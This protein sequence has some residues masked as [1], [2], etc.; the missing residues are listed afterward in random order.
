[1]Q[2]LT[3]TVRLPCWDPDVGVLWAGADTDCTTRTGV[4]GLVPGARSGSAQEDL[5]TLQ[6]KA[7]SGGLVGAFWVAVK[8]F[9]Y[10]VYSTRKIIYI[11][12]HRYQRTGFLNYG[13][14][15]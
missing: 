1:M 7:V 11:Y 2:T 3:L 6:P 4:D 14:L 10:F 8:E 12:I 9:T 13:N 15:I 5:R